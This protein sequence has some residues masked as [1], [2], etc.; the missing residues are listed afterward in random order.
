MTSREESIT[1]LNKNNIVNI[2]VG[3]LLGVNTSN[4]GFS[5]QTKR[6]KIL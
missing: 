1:F 4:F 3:N 2:L 5:H 6:A